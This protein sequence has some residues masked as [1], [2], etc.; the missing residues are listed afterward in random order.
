MIKIIIVPK[1]REMNVEKKRCGE[2]MVM[3]RLNYGHEP[4]QKGHQSLRGPC[5]FKK[6]IRRKEKKN[7]IKQ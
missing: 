6:I 7:Y 5:K 1:Q 3:C 4:N 2:V